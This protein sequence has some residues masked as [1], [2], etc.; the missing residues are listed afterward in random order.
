M[1]DNPDAIPVLSE[2][3]YIEVMARRIYDAN[4]PQYT[5]TFTTEGRHAEPTLLTWE[6]E[7]E[8]RREWCRARAR[9][10]IESW[11]R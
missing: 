8:Y 7:D 1:S 3:E 5:T 11:R 9:E 2:A 6:T 10:L 4:P